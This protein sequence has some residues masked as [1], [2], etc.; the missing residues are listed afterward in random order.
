MSEFDDKAISW[1]DDPER[2][3]RANE[4]GEFIISHLDLSK[5]TTAL[6]YGSGT[7]LLSFAL[8]DYISTITLMDASEMMTAVTV[9][10]VAAKNAKHLLPVWGDLIRDEYPALKVDLIFTMLTM[11]HIDD[12]ETILAKFR[13]HLNPQGNLVIIDL[14][15]EDGSFHEGEFHG[16]KGFERDQLEQTLSDSGFKP[17]SYNICYEITKVTEEGIKKSYPVFMLVAEKN[18]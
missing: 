10:K 18:K 11:H 4:I 9:K 5:V 17:K 12:I 13:Q 14:E 8:K 1:D 2:L 3:A 16:H 15:K 6:E 7:G